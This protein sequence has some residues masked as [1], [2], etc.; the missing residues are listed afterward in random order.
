MPAFKD[1]KPTVIGV[2]IALVI[3]AALITRPTWG[4]AE[5]ATLAAAIGSALLGLFTKFPDPALTIT[6]TTSVTLPDEE[7]KP[8][9]KP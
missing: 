2:L 6:S 8:K 5:L 3:V 4:P 1:W 9:P 7:A